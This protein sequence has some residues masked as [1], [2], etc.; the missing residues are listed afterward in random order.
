MFGWKTFQTNPER[1]FSSQKPQLEVRSSKNKAPSS[2]SPLEEKKKTVCNKKPSAHQ[3]Y[4]V[5]SNYCWKIN[6][7]HRTTLNHHRHYRDPLPMISPSKKNKKNSAPRRF[8]PRTW[9]FLRVIGHVL[10]RCSLGRP[11][12]QWMF[13]ILGGKAGLGREKFIL[14]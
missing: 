14:A 11:W 7:P 5:Q 13:L 3:S 2:H 12:H 8:T 10:A 6:V 4:H 9:H 1:G